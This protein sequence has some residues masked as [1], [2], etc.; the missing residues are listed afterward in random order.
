[1][2]KDYHGEP[3]TGIREEFPN[4]V[5]VS[6][7]DAI[8]SDQLVRIER[9]LA[10]ILTALRPPAK[11]E[12]VGPAGSPYQA[13]RYGPTCHLCGGS[14]IIFNIDGSS[15]DCRCHGTGLL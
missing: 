8:L 6:D 7:K 14:G 12:A 4:I 1:M 3:F 9:L 11:I 13:R 5:F 2:S 15:K 10:D